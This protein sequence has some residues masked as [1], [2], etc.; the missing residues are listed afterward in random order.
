MSKM[1]LGLIATTAL[2]VLAAIAG[3]CSKETPTAPG[4]APQTSGNLLMF[5]FQDQL[6]PFFLVGDPKTP[7]D[8]GDDVLLGV[9][10]TFFGDTSSSVLEI[11]DFTQAN[12]YR[13]YS[14]PAAGQE[15]RPAT[16]FDF[17]PSD[18]QISRHVD[19]GGVVHPAGVKGSSEYMV[20]GVLNGTITPSSPYTNTV[21]PWG[22]TDDGLVLNFDRVQTDSVL[23]VSFEPDARAVIYVLE[24]SLFAN[25]NQRSLLHH[26]SLPLPI[27]FSHKYSRWGFVPRGGESNIRIPLYRVPFQKIFPLQVVVRV[28]AIDTYGRV[29]SRSPSD[30]VQNQQGS[31]GTY[32]YYALDPCGGFF[33]VANPYPKGYGLTAGTTGAVSVDG[34]LTSTP[35]VTNEDMKR[36]LASRARMAVSERFVVSPFQPVSPLLPSPDLPELSQKLP[37]GILPPFK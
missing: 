10:A 29:V 27:A 8:P 4:Q 33:M 7:G 32:N 18:K 19:I 17:T 15:F 9:A 31:D 25:I 24:L 28:S 37:P 5:G 36:F 35:F 23:T 20:T 1:R 11:V 12:A 34:A 2:A 26:G 30:Y 6:I 16:D 13:P 3:G 14:R 21:V 22:P